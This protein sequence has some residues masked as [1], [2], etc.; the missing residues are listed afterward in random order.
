M[1][2]PIQ[3]DLNADIGEGCAHDE[4]L[5]QLVTS[6]NVACAFHAGDAPTILHTLERASALGVRAGAHP[7]FPDQEH[8]GRREIARSEREIFADCIYQVGA[9]VALAR[10]AGH[11]PSHIKPHG[12][13]YNLACRDESFAE[14]IVRVAELFELP[15]VALPGSVLERKCEGRVRF[16]REGFADRR[17][18]PD[19]SLVPRTEP[20]AL[21]HDPAE[22]VAQ[23]GRLLRTTGIRTL[24]VHGDHP[25]AVRFVRELRSAL[26]DQGITL[27]AFG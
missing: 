4:E 19:G 1:S 5:L 15:I 13:L 7:A 18:R 3:L 10:A 26:V 17:Y 6:V 8:F 9:F 14:P 21:V 24:C 25:E 23:A 16:I 2:T 22:A 12:A 27:E 20:D 11:Q